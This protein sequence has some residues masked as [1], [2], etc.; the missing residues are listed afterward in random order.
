MKKWF[1]LT[2]LVMN[3][4]VQTF[5]QLNAD[6]N[7]AA[8]GFNA[9]GSD[10]SAIKIADEVMAAM[11]G[12]ANWD[13]TRYI[14]W[15]FFGRRML[16]WDKHQG[17]V[18]VE[19]GDEIY[20]IDLFKNTGKVKIGDEILTNQDSIAKYVDR[21]ISIWINDSYWLVMPFKLKDSGVTLKYVGEEK[22]TAGATADVLQ[23]T[24]EEVGRTPDN[25]YQV[26]VDKK[27]RLIT[28]WDFYTNYQDEKPR[29][30][31]AWDN[32]K[33]YGKILL[34]DGRGERKHTNVGVYTSIP[35]SVFTSFDPVNYAKFR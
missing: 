27:S 2:F 19:S 25:K 7:P 18:R 32:Y 11:G 26:Y 15:K 28:Q 4:G 1:V 21:G 17:K 14:T 6:P 33:Q 30:S 23:L 16:I 22:T 12:R 34:S 5:A 8:P 9:A 13:D 31:N 3:I 20:L 29:F 35:E 10:L 24:F